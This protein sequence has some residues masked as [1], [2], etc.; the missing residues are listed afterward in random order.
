MFLDECLN[1]NN[2]TA[3]CISLYACPT[4]V[5]IFLNSP[6]NVEDQRFLEES[7]CG[8]GFGSPPHV[9]CSNE[10]S[11]SEIKLPPSKPK[12]NELPGSDECIWK[13]EDMDINESYIFGI[14]EGSILN[15]ILIIQI[16]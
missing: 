8:D 1:P 12:S 3:V 13:Q 2:I 14:L 4:L 11:F 7:Y 15:F 16:F 5:D 6:E 9:C 10:I